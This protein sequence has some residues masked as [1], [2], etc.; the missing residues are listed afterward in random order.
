ML[1]LGPF[2]VMH[3]NANGTQDY[4]DRYGNGIYNVSQTIRSA[5]KSWTQASEDNKKEVYN[6]K[7]SKVKFLQVV[8][9]F[10][11]HTLFGL[12]L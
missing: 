1:F 3:T 12:S 5:P 9:N 8:H 4:V 11:T 10:F 2:E 7:W 6:K